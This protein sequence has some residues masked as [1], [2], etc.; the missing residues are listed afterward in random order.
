MSVYVELWDLCSSLFFHKGLTVISTDDDQLQLRSLLNAVEGL[1]RKHNPRKRYGPQQD[2]WCSFATG[3]VMCAHVISATQSESDSF[4]YCVMILAKAI[5]IEQAVTAGLNNKILMDRAYS[6]TKNVNLCAKIRLWHIGCIKSSIAPHTDKDRSTRAKVTQKHILPDGFAADYYASY[7][8]PD[9]M[10]KM[11]NLCRRNG[12]GK[13]VHLQHHESEGEPYAYDVE[14]KDGHTDD[15]PTPLSAEEAERLRNFISWEASVTLLTSAQGTPDW[16][17]LRMFGI[18]GTTAEALVK[19]YKSKVPELGLGWLLNS[20]GVPSE[21]EELSTS[22]QIFTD[23]TIAQL[24]VLELQQLLQLHRIPRLPL[25]TASNEKNKANL[26]RSFKAALTPID[27]SPSPPTYKLL[28]NEELR[29]IP[30][31]SL[32]LQKCFES[33][34]YNN[35]L[36]GSTDAGVKR[37]FLAGHLNEPRVLTALPSFLTEHIPGVVL[38]ILRTYWFSNE[39]ARYLRVS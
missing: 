20:L 6:G 36:Q 3:A 19:L 13:L 17:L 31:E 22:A 9:N 18:S 15:A 39:G 38:G 28:N 35:K 29:R 14:L 37:T 2:V 4:N 26:V 24:K 16:H 1:T 32:I 10:G 11:I 27:N 7:P 8:L 33:W 25:D 5:T 23:A 30:V 34:F 21:A 12:T